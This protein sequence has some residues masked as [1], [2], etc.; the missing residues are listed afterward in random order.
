MGIAM[1]AAME[2]AID[3]QMHAA[4]AQRK[5][6]QGSASEHFNHGDYEYGSKFLITSMLVLTLG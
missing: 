2:T 5:A 3:S 6:A 1:V 4:G